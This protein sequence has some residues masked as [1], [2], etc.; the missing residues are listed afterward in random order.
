MELIERWAVVSRSLLVHCKYSCNLLNPDAE[1]VGL[2][3][4]IQLRTEQRT[5]PGRGHSSYDNAAAV[6]ALLQ[7]ETA[8]ILRVAHVMAT[9]S[10]QRREG[11]MS[12]R[13]VGQRFVGRSGKHGF[14]PAGGAEQ[15]GQ[16]RP[17]LFIREAAAA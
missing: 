4:L 10:R 17:Q 5:Q 11:F 3:V 9:A 15:A 12:G 8:G 2:S 14:I 16:R 6:L 7:H 1:G 13:W